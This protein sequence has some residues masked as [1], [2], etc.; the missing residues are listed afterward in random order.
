[1]VQAEAADEEEEDLQYTLQ[2]RA[3]RGDQAD[4]GQD[5]RDPGPGIALVVV[6]LLA[7]GNDVSDGADLVHAGDH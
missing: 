2:Q 4:Q 1:M 5:Q 6:D 3:Q 7:V